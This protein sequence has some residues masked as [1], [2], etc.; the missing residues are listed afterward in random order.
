MNGDSETRDIAGS[1]RNVIGAASISRRGGSSWPLWAMGV[2]AFALR[3]APML[4]H[5][6]GWA[7]GNSDSRRYVELAE[8]MRA[9]CGFAPL[10][11]GRC[12]LPEVLRTPGYPLLLAATPSLGAALFVQAVI[13]AAL[14]VAVGYFVFMWWGGRAALIAET[15][16]VLDA[17]SIIQGSRILSD[18]LFQAMLAVAVIVQL[19]VIACGRFDRRA[20]IELFGS[21]FLL[22]ASIM[23]RPVGFLLPLIAPLPFFF[24]PRNNWRKTVGCALC[25]F[26]LPA[27]AVGGWMARN[28]AE[29]GVW[30]LS[31]DVALDLYYFKAGGVIWYREA[32]PF[33][34]IMDELARRIGRPNANDYPDTPVGLAPRMTRDAVKILM[35]DPVATIITTLR[36]FVWLAVV[37]DRGGLNEL[38]NENAGATSYLAA[39]GQIR[40]RLRQLFHSPLLTALVVLQLALNSLVWIGVARAILAWRWSS[41]REIAVEIIPLV[42]ALAMIGLA[43]GAEAYAR[44][45]MPAAPLLAILAGI[46]WAGARLPFGPREQESHI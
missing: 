12:G 26:A 19:G 30:T 16:I 14:C 28:A 39:T 23:V 25:A 7:M 6:L 24:L 35:H 3:L 1:F 13:G 33:P 15:L 41:S 45:R 36:S 42:I 32:R 22:A 21:A 27:L 31:T 46:G 44:Y 40:A 43:A 10:V 11:D 37:P 20:I 9:G 29:T 2:A 5:S 17:P 38:I 18:S 4:R 8:G 34:A